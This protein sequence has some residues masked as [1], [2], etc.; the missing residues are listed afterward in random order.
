MRGIVV[1]D[2]EEDFTADPVEL[3]F[4]LAYV[5]AFSRLVA[6]LIHHPDWTGAGEALLLFL[7]IWFSWS[8]FTWIANGVS[9][10]GRIARTIF[11]IA[12]ALTVPMAASVETA[13]DDGG[14]TFAFSAALI[15]AIS[16]V[17][18]VVVHEPGSEHRQSALQL[19]IPSAL[20]LGVLL[21]GGYVDTP[22]R[23][24]LWILSLAILFGSTA[25]AGRNDW[26]VRSGHFAE[27]HGLIL[28][29]ALGE[30]IVAIGIS[31]TNG[32]DDGGLTANIRLG[33]FAAGIFAG[34]LWWSYFD[35]VLPALEHRAESLDNA[36]RGR[37][38]R[39]VYTWGHA[40]I[41][42]GVIVAAAAG[43][44]ILLHPSDHLHSE[45]R[46]MFAIGI[47][48]F[49]CG[50]G[51]TVYRSFQVVAKERLV[52]LGVIVV[53]CMISG[54]WEAVWLLVA[55]DVVLLVVLLVE[56][57]RVEKRPNAIDREA[58]R[59]ANDASGE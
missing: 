50:I 58:E 52:G 22:A 9:G 47:A 31:V 18:G 13:F 29:I 45:F 39:D 53:L 34:L 17:L 48:M 43:E 38:A 19:S 12:T 54:S 8:W 41:I 49:L 10:N 3:F 44:E 21:V 59:I 23:V 55:V 24:W 28:I 14:S 20:A 40:P 57:Y 16:N 6:H 5:F 1:P 56:H 15:M 51:I 36:S 37:F 4:D 33:L 30:V 27:R 25:F 42:G 7:I 46:W 26:I 2:R 32:F 35:R 11:L